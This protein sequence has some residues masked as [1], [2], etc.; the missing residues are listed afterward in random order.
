MA[1]GMAGTEVPAR[2]DITRDGRTIVGMTSNT[3]SIRAIPGRASVQG[4]EVRVYRN[5]SNQVPEVWSIAAN[6]G[7]DAGKVI[8][9]TDEVSLVG[10]RMFVRREAHRKTLAGETKRGMKRNVLAWTI[11]K[12]A[13]GEVV[14][15]GRRIDFDFFPV[16][17]RPCGE[18]YETE[19]KDLVHEA[20]AVRFTAVTG[21]DMKRHGVSEV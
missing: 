8:A 10:C 9:Y 19:S 1:V 11:G 5:L 15:A 14:I 21:S 7:P 4:I 18:F 12:V 20:G 13:D 2:F 17:G 6:E 16:E 3:S